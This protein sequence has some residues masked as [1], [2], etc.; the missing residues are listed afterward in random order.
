M[1]LATSFGDATRILPQLATLPVSLVGI[2]VAAAL[3]RE[4]GRE[5]ATR[6]GSVLS[7][8]LPRG[9]GLLLGVVDGRNTRLEDPEDV[10]E[11][12]L[13]PILEELRAFGSPPRDVHLAPNHGLEFLPRDTARAKMT[14]LAAVCSRARTVFA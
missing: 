13:R 10:F 4:D 5:A 9:V 14:I 7:E 12:R 8:A 11:S 2:D 3:G 6:L 1:L